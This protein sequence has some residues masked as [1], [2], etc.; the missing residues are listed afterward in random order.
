[1]P[2]RPHVVAPIKK[3][4][5]KKQVLD[6]PEFYRMRDENGTGTVLMLSNKD[7]PAFARESGDRA[8][9]AANL[10]TERLSRH[11]VVPISG[12]EYDGRSYVI[13]PMLRPIS[14][15]RALRSVQIGL[16]TNT[17]AH[18]LKDL[19]SE[20]VRPV[21]SRADLEDGYIEPYQY[22]MEETQVPDCVRRHAE[23][24][25]VSIEAGRFHPVS[26]L[27]HGD[28]WYGNVLLGSGWPLTPEGL[29]HFGVIDWAG[30][31][32]QGYPYADLTRFFRSLGRSRRDRAPH[33]KAYAAS[34]NVPLDH[35]VDYLLA[36]VGKLGLNRGQF[37][38]ERYIAGV[39][40]VYKTGMNMQA[41]CGYQPS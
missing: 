38:F 16:V 35:L 41:A 20:T 33:F 31:T 12:G 19:A 24:A 25:L 32:I 23:N 37:G 34:T 10:L 14:S 6:S 1:M 40:D 36:F 18:W 7:F 39:S 26:T 2:L 17:V 3:A 30:S 11:V 22:L 28:F 13:Y 4:D 8:Q 15:K 21:T 29:F 9:A 27:T 5:F